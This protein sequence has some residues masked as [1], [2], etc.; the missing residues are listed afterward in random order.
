MHLANIV[1]SGRMAAL[2]DDGGGGLIVKGDE[3]PGAH[4]RNQVVYFAQIFGSSSKRHNRRVYHQPHVCSR[5]IEIENLLLL[6]SLLLTHHWR[7][8]AHCIDTHLYPTFSHVPN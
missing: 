8:M 7:I 5:T 2:D 6:H 1:L 4:I 3:K